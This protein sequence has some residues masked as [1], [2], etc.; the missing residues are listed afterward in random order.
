MNDSRIVPCAFRRREDLLFDYSIARQR[1]SAAGGKAN[2]LQSMTI[3][4]DTSA[5]RCASC[6]HMSTTGMALQSLL[7]PS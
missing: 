4:T 2:K 3:N 6:D 1:R 7:G 5:E